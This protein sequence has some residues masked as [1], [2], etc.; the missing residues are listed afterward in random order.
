MI[1]HA[2]PDTRKHLIRH[3]VR[4]AQ[5]QPT[6]SEITVELINREQPRMY[7]WSYQLDDE[8]QFISHLNAYSYLYE[9]LLTALYREKGREPPSV[10]IVFEFTGAVLL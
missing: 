10:S 3:A 6:N 9:K 5:N 4:V 2:S 8:Q 7:P 1:T